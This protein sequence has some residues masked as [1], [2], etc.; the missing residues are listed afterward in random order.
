M[1]MLKYILLFI[2]KGKLMKNNHNLL[3]KMKNLEK[4]SGAIK[5]CVAIAMASMLFATT[6]FSLDTHPVKAQEVSSSADKI[7]IPEISKDAF[8]KYKKISGIGAN[9]ILGAD[10]TYYQ[11][12]LEWG[13]SYKNYMSQ[14]VDN[15]FDYVK[16]QGINT[17]SLKVAVNPTGE[18]AY[19]S[20]ENAI[21][22]LK[23]VKASNTNLK[24]NL[25]LL[26]SDEITYAGTQN[27]PADW[28]KAEKEEQSVT[29][30]ES[31]KTYTRETI[32]KLKQAK[33][34]PDIVTI[35]NEVNWNFLGITDGEGWEGWKA[36]GDISALLKKE[37]VKNAVSIAA[38]P[39]AASVKY[40]V[41]KL[42]YASVDYDYIGVN[43]YPDNNTNSYI[44]SLKNEVESCAPDK[45][46]IV[47]NVEYERVN[48]ANTANVYTQADSIYNLLEATID[49]KNAGGLIYNEAAY[50]G[51]WK[52]F[53]DDEGDA[54]VSMAIFAYAQ[55]NE[56]DTSRDPY[57][58]GDDTGLKQQ[59]VTIK[60]VKNMS[61]STIRGIDISSYTALKKAGV[62]YYDNE[63]K[64]ASL[65]KVLS[66][67][68]VNYIR[69]RIWN[70]PYNEKG[71]TYGGGSNDV[72]A[73]LE[74]AKEAAKYNIKVLLGFHYSDFWADPAVQLLPKA[75]EKDRNNQEKMCSNVYEF[76]KETLEQF[77]DAGADIGMVQVGNEISQGMM[78]IMHRTK[79]NVWQ[80]EEKSVLIDSY[81]NAGARAVRECV[82]DALVAI[83]LDTLNLSIYK[84]AMN[85]WER[86]KVDY[87]V[88]GS[89]SYAFWA[90]KNMLGNVRKAG[91]YVASRGKLFAVLETSWLNSQKDADGTVN[92]VNNTKDAVYKVG[93]QGQA[94]MLSDL[95]DAIL[96]ND[97]GLGAFYWEGAWIPVKAGWVNWKYNKEMANEFGT[98]WATENAGGYYPKSK[99]YYN[100]NPVWG[101]DSWDNQTLFDDKGY[102][103]DSL[104]FYKDAVSSNEK[105]SRVVIALCDKENNV[106][107]YRVVKVVSGKSMTYTLPE[108]KGYTKE[109]DTIKILGTNDKISKVSVV[110]NKD[111]KKQTI[112]VKKASYTIPYGT[113]FNL[114]NKVKAVGSLTFTSNNTNIVSVE[115]QGKKLVVKKPGKVKI[116]ITAGAT[117]DYK[118]TSRIVTIYAVPKKQTIKKVSTAKR[119]VKVNIKKDVKA[120]GYQIVAAKNSRFSK[121][122]KVLT[123]KGTRQV[124]YTI[125]KLNSRKIYYVKARAYKTIGNKKYFGPWSKVKK[126]RVK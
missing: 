60:K 41:Q 8:K 6:G 106:L 21:K 117:A 20:L 34:L 78:G 77:K 84:D 22:T 58:Y 104:R 93:P 48:E 68:G 97:N 12:C 81:L 95:Y 30:V 10:F 96:S 35:G 46:L 61:D 114:K 99:L 90:G 83:H 55:G 70:D 98:G 112:T 52:S 116:K 122:K 29:R 74:I 13:K 121:G 123:K 79:A 100:G 43:V 56:T 50:V 31:A 115:K 125:T 89:S 86:D 105:Y 118:Q 51:S 47:S 85:A 120:T 111:I 9:T 54:Q 67:N 126:I 119:K 124:T 49:E 80:E 36:M 109:K 110:Y 71:E 25:V 18:N 64:E 38:Q 7:E 23:A 17:I 69:I 101:G 57:K 113:K 1:D 19:L 42:G 63:G 92:M 88:L 76:T 62:K 16:S 4:F 28:E 107:E 66:D 45:Q 32:A 108:I 103:L 87:D 14:S 39:D 102:P 82:P 15:I 94:D 44:K 40:I 24:T 5:R 2:R 11:Q 65:L 3:M 59:K 33:V 37:G 75:W 72:K 27:L 26:Y 73:G 91:N 53:F